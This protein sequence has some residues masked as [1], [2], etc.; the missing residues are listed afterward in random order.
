[1]MWELFE[2]CYRSAQ[3]I[4]HFYYKYRHLIY[5]S[6]WLLVSFIWANWECFVI[7]ILCFQNSKANYQSFVMMLYKI[8]HYDQ[9]CAWSGTID[10]TL[11]TFVSHFVEIHPTDWDTQVQKSKGKEMSLYHRV[12][13]LRWIQTVISCY[14]ELITVDMSQRER[15]W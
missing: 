8:H 4:F 12:K 3:N 11:L 13:D 9:H 2:E 5:G 14:Q 10:R 1:M 15:F 6:V 7:K